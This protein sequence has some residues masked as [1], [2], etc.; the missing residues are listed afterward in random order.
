MQMDG[1]GKRLRDAREAAGLSGRALAAKTGLSPT[2]ISKIEAGK[3]GARLETIERL[4]QAL[5]IHPRELAYG[6]R[7]I[8]SEEKEA[9]RASVRRASF[10]GFLE[11]MRLRADVGITRDE[12]ARRTR[13]KVEVV[14]DIEEGKLVPDGRQ[15]VLLETV[16]DGPLRQISW[17]DFD[18]YLTATTAT[19]D[20][21]PGLL[22][23]AASPLAECLGLTPL[24]IVLLNIMAR[25]A[26]YFTPEGDE[27]W[28]ELAL[29]LRRD[30]GQYDF[31]LVP[32][33]PVEVLL[34]F[35][36]ERERAQISAGS[37]V[38]TSDD[39]T[40]AVAPSARSHDP[41]DQGD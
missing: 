9:A 2:A 41:P 15:R 19:R 25:Q 18:A 4:S 38:Q 27:E 12:L 3:Q 34:Q 29:A 40:G 37:T 6:V 7:R 11:V 14:S 21:V 20:W 32:D 8:T 31:H 16:L 1:L 36:R 17:G 35:E 39:T 5:G 10:R 28:T 30:Y 23:F 33:L 22:E 24:H 13:L 26:E